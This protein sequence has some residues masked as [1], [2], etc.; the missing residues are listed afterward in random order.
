MSCSR[1]VHPIRKVTGTL[2]HYALRE[3]PLDH[4]SRD[5]RHRVETLQYRTFHA[6]H[7][8]LQELTLEQP[9]SECHVNLEIL[10]V[11]PCL[12][13]N[14]ARGYQRGWGADERRSN[15]QHEIRPPEYLPHHD[16]KRR[17]RKGQQVHDPSK[18]VGRLRDP[19]G[20]SPHIYTAPLLA[21]KWRPD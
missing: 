20:R 11:Q 4:S 13:P 3:E 6:Q 18:S 14:Q 8:S 2:G 17:D 1:D 16:G 10:K 15:S 19:K 5:A 7:D 21:A 9:Q 12:C